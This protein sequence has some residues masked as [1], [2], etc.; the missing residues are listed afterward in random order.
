MHKNHEEYLT[1]HATAL[2]TLTDFCA[3]Y[4]VP[5]ECDLSVITP[6][7]CAIHIWDSDTDQEREAKLFA[8][9][10]AFG[11]DGWTSNQTSAC[12]WNWTKTLDGVEITIKGA[13]RM[14]EPKPQPVAPREFPL[15]L[16]EVA[17]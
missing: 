14:P 11:T 7:S 12:K 2:Q 16:T 8:M 13:K 10:D 17:Q 9:G 3:K 1:R 15:Q 4:D 6:V 5:K